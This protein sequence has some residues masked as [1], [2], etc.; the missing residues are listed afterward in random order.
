MAILLSVVSVAFMFDFLDRES[1]HCTVTGELDSRQ[2][3]L[4]QKQFAPEIDKRNTAQVNHHP[5]RLGRKC[6]GI[7]CPLQLLDPRPHEFAFQLEYGRFGVRIYRYLQHAR[8][9]CLSNG[10]FVSGG[11]SS[12]LE[13]FRSVPADARNK[14]RMVAKLRHR[15]NTR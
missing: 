2:M 14:C 1:R 3:H 7:P 8:P 9:W 4:S 11:S 5:S 13:S 12:S 10:N 15:E 6:D